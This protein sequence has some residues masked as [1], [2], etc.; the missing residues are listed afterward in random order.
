MTRQDQETRGRGQL[1]LI[2]GALFVLIL[3]P[4]LAEWLR[5]QTVRLAGQLVTL[6][7]SGALFWQVFSG[8]RWARHVTVTLAFVGGIVAVFL[9]LLVS[10]GSSAG[11][12]VFFVG[13][14]FIACGFALIALPDVDAYLRSRRAR[15]LGKRA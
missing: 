6:A 2:L 12:F 7:L 13:L 9:G 14:A 3:A 10:A 15:R 8:A 1:L 4:S 11:L 5:G